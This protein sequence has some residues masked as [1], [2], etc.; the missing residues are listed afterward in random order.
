MPDGRPPLSNDARKVLFWQRVDYGGSGCW[1]WLAGCTGD[2]YGQFFYDGVAHPAHVLV[3]TW[4]HGAPEPRLQVQH[5]C[6][7]KP[8]V[9]P[10]HLLV[11]TASQNKLDAWARGRIPRTLTRK[12]STDDRLCI[13]Q[14]YANGVGVTELARRYDV[15][16]STIHELIHRDR[17]YKYIDA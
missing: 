11:G 14:L 6:D 16:H 2:G 3:W 9:R 4:L 8:C 5:K 1:L 7:V 10:S 13:L 15:A 17:Q 12:I